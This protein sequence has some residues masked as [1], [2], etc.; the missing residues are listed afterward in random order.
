M[1]PIYAGLVRED[2]NVM[3]CFDRRK[4]E[5]ALHAQNCFGCIC[6]LIAADVCLSRC[7]SSSVQYNVLPL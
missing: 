5:T 4:K 7:T 2:A 6:S 3:S 1:R